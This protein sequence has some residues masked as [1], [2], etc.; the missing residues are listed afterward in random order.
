MKWRVRSTTISGGLEVP[1]DKSIGHRALMLAALAQGRST[2]RHLPGGEDVRATA[3]CVGRLGVDLVDLGNGVV[4]VHGG[5]LRVPEAD[6]YTAN[7][8]T[9]MRLLSGILAGQPFPSVLT[10]DASLSRRPMSRVVHPL[11]AMGAHIESD[12]FPRWLSRAA[13]CTASATGYP[14]PAPR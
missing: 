5:D 2:I 14:W 4:D 9:T 3:A 6:L 11:R 13:A 12:G 8:G 7:S 10:G 1:G